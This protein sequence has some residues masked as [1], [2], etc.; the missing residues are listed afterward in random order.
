MQNTGVRIKK[1]NLYIKEPYVNL[2]E[3]RKTATKEL[4][5]IIVDWGI[6]LDFL[7]I[8]SSNIREG[9]EWAYGQAKQNN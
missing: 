3:L 9:N 1:A 7:Q 6:L 5:Q 4:N 2:I 8:K